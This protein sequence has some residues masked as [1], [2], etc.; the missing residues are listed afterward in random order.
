MNRE[1]ILIEANE[2][3]EK[4]GNK[5]LRIFD[6][7]ILFF[8]NEG[9]PTAYEQYVKGHIP[10][11]SFFDHQN[12]SDTTSNYIFMMLP[13]SE[14]QQQI[15][16]L[17]ITE[18]SEVIFYSTGMLPCATRAWWILKYA[19]HD[20]VRVLNGGLPAWKKINKLTEQGALHYEPSTFECQLQRWMFADKNEVQAA[21]NNKHVSLI[22]TL[23]KDEYDNE[24]IVSSL[25][26]PF[27]ELTQNR[28]SFLS[29]DKISIRLKNESDSKKTIVYC[30]GGIGATV[31]A[32][33]Y[34]MAGNENIS[35]YDGSMSEWVGESLPTIKGDT[36]NTV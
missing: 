36:K 27:E 12:F 30:G 35:V 31:N 6:A 21:I 15:R 16:N 24:H 11:A 29:T 20:N 1:S 18:D 2:L 17:G 9:D 19:G 23:S 25:S 10:G 34:L 33:A 32:I 8:T 14:L 22:N 13:K 28:M 4:L 3:S 5:N 7:T 26:F